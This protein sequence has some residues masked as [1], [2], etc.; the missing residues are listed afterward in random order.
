[1]EQFTS[2]QR[3]TLAPDLEYLLSTHYYNKRQSIIQ[4]GGYDERIK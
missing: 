2:V 1:M 3:Q 4:H